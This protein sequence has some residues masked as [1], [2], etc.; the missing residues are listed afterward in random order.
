[1]AVLTLPAALD[2][3]RVRRMVP[4]LIRL[5]A[6]VARSG[7]GGH[8]D[9]RV[10]AGRNVQ[11]EVAT[12]GVRQ[13]TDTGTADVHLDRLQRTL[14][15]SIPHRTHQRPSCLSR[16]RCRRPSKHGGESQNKPP[17][18]QPGCETCRR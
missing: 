1:M 2:R 18:H 14:R 10:L 8:R 12:R 15:S 3:A 7:D 11:Q 6:A 9:D 5:V 17:A 4:D 16:D 13:G